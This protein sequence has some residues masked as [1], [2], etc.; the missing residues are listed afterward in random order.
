VFVYDKATIS[1]CV[2]YAE[3]RILNFSKLLFQSNRRMYQFSRESSATAVK[4]FASEFLV[5]M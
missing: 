4:N 2:S 3:T 5:V 1:S